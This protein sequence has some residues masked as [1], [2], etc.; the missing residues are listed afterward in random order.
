MKLKEKLDAFNTDFMTKVPK[1]AQ[2]IM[3][4]A[5]EDLRRSGILGHVLRVGDKVPD[6]ALP[7]AEGSIVNSSELC[8][9]G[10]LVVCFYRG[11][12]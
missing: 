6:F 9:R 1:A 4:R 8:K 10:P 3:H 5:T 2:E 12:W 7:N 11:V